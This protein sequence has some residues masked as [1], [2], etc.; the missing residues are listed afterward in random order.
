MTINKKLTFGIISFSLL[1]GISCSLLFKNHLNIPSLALSPLLLQGEKE[2]NLYDLNDQRIRLIYFGYTH[3]PD[4]CPTSLAIL[5]LALKNTPKKQLDKIR[6]LFITL[7]PK[8]DTGAKTAKY[9]QYFHPRIEGLSGNDAQIKQLIDKYGILYQITALPESKINY[10]VDHSS[11]FYFISPNGDLLEKIPH[12]LN[13][14]MITDA[15]LRLTQIN[16]K[17]A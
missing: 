9:A 4:I 12:T 6:P 8:R 2:I 1:A 16:P 15:I 3:C 13:D 7:D 5:S 17:G 11:Y 14:K 10:A